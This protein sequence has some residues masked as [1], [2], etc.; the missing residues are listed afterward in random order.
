MSTMFYFQHVKCLHNLSKYHLKII[1]E[2]HEKCHSTQN[3]TCDMLS[4]LFTFCF[5]LMIYRKYMKV[6]CFHLTVALKI[7]FQF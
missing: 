7:L 3:D 1:S 6:I 4:L 2:L 5:I